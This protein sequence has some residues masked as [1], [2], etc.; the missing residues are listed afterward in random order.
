MVLI[1]LIVLWFH[2]NRLKDVGKAKAEVAADF[3]M[4]RVKGVK[5]KHYNRRIE[6]FDKSWYTHS[7]ATIAFVGWRTIDHSLI[8]WPIDVVIRYA[9]F[10]YVIAGLDNVQARQW[11]NATLVDL[12][13]FT[14]TGEVDWKTVVPLIDGGTEAFSG[15]VCAPHSCPSMYLMLVCSCGCIANRRVCSC[16]TS[17]HVS[18][19]PSIVCHQLKVMPCVPLRISHVYLNTVSCM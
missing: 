14:P 6:T 19:V 18:N 3:V 4:K 1:T 9:Q 17:H 13:Q 8:D 11:L 2:D 16:P 10:D 7:L 12:V 15:Q 5:I